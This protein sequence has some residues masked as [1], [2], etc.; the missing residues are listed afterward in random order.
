MSKLKLTLACWNYD[1]TRPL[2]DG[3]VQPEGIE[4]DIQL[5]RP[6]V[7]FERMLDHKEFQASELSLASYTALKGR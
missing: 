1:R 5:H 3:R 4:L 7:T 6:R 2:I